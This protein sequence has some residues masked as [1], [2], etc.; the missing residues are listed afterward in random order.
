M[1]LFLTGLT[2][3]KAFR[4][5]LT[6]EIYDRLETTTYALLS[7]MDINYD[8]LLILPDNLADPRLNQ[9]Q[10]GLYAHIIVNDFE[11]FWQSPSMSDISLP[12]T[13]PKTAG[14]FTRNLTDYKNQELLSL[15][16]QVVWDDGRNQFI[17]ATI[18]VF[19]DRAIAY[20]HLAQFRYQLWLWLSIA[21]LGLLVVQVIL[22]RWVLKPVNQI[23]DQINQMEQG[24][25]E[26]IE[27]IFPTEL[28]KLVSNLNRLI[29]HEREQ[30]AR[31]QHSLADLAHSLKTPLA[32]V[33]SSLSQDKI[34]TEVLHEEI[35]KVTDLIHYQLRRAKTSGNP[36]T[37]KPIKIATIVN[38]LCDALK[39]VYFDKGIACTVV[40]DKELKISIHKDDLLECLGNVIENAFK[41]AHKEVKVSATQ[42][43]NQISVV[44]EDDGN[45]IP[46][47]DRQSVLQR[48]VRKVESIEGQ[49]IGL[50]VV[51][52]VM[53]V[54]KGEISIS[55]SQQLGGAKIQLTFNTV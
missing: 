34:E 19:E 5:S 50:A 29:L 9:T 46:E 20:A 13:I 54:Y 2:L 31:Y 4:T 43:S 48:G 39:K 28:K 41:F 45:G 14:Q 55:D 18:Q 40:I 53:S 32:V 3:E 38:S 51:N 10:S 52:E 37:S 17:N 44:I 8:G 30:R 24:Q 21:L 1:F 7:S 49:G 25:Q 16:Y 35:N 22:F 11:Q 33:K 26:T 27:G 6:E 47:N 42:R 36:I 12:I 15:T 23:S